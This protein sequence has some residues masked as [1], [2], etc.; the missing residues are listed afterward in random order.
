[1]QYLQHAGPFFRL[2]WDPIRVLEILQC[3]S[4]PLINRVV[5]HTSLENLACNWFWV[6]L[7][8][9][10]PNSSML[11]IPC[12]CTDKK[13][14]PTVSL[15]DYVVFCLDPFPLAKIWNSCIS[16]SNC[17]GSCVCCMLRWTFGPQNPNHTWVYQVPTGAFPFMPLQS[18][19]PLSSP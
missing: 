1:M 11:I 12:K 17:D 3:R 19:L 6:W 9:R 13:R 4:W 16:G 7:R 5:K 2:A 8:S 14:L 10:L 15:D 18:P